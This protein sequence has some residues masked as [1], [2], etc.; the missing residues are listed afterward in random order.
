[1]KEEGSG[2]APEGRGPVDEAAAIIRRASEAGRL[3]SE[4]EIGRALAGSRPGAEADAGAEVR[5]R[6]LTL[7]GEGDDVHEVVA[8]KGERF[9]YS[10][11]S[12]SEAYSAILL[13]RQGDPARLIAEIVR[14]DSEVYPRP[15]PLDMF[16]HPPFDFTLNEVARTLEKMAAREEYSDIE[17]TR[18]S[19]AR[20]FLYSTLYLE[21]AHASML[22]EWLDV[23]QSNN[24]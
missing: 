8:D 16:T 11:R 15:V 6:L 14:H 24:P 23:G 7:L 18:T 21:P 4:A 1:M 5:S 19:T 2:G 20:L 17:E 10:S 3:I 12:M 13:G 9:Y 22:A